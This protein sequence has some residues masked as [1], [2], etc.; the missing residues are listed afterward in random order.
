M[1]QDP[2][3][4]PH[5]TTFDGFRFT[6]VGADGKVTGSAKFTDSGPSF[7]FWGVGKRVW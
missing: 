1:M 7:P 2:E 5:P 3:H 6:T 4:Y